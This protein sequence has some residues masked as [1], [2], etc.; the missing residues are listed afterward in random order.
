MG[1]SCAETLARFGVGRLILVDHDRVQLSNLNRQVI[2][3][4]STLGQL[5]TEAT[6]ARLRD[7]NPAVRLDLCPVFYNRKTADS[8]PLDAADAVIDCVDTL[9]AKLLLAEKAQAGSFILLSAMG[10]GNRQDPLRFRFADIY[11]TQ[12]CP[13]ARRMRKA[14][15]ER[16]IQRLRVLYS[17]EEPMPLNIKNASSRPTPGTLSHVPPVAGMALAGEAIRLLLG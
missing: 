1:G 2:A 9:E 13:L 8:V 3:L 15:R 16:G 17:D 11:Q 12:V 7:I 4:Y 5:K 10:A 14:C 6:G